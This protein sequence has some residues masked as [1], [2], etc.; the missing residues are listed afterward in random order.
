MVIDFDYNRVYGH[1]LKRYLL[2]AILP[3]GHLAFGNVIEQQ[4]I[5]TAPS[6]EPSPLDWTLEPTFRGTGER[7][8]FI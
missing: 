2:F 5:V 6:G 1:I 3:K 7:N 8:A 4:R